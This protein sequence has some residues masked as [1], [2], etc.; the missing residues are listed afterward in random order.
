MKGLSECKASESNIRRIQTKY[1]EVL[2]KVRGD[3]TLTILLTFE[4]EQAELKL[5]SEDVSK[6]GRALNTSYGLHRI[7]DMLQ[8][9]P[10]RI[11]PRISINREWSE[12]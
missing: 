10:L 1:A 12:E 3:N 5:F 2:R 4:E 11:Q 7:L 9:P 8:L 6:N